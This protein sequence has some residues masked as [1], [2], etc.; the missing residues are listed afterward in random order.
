[1]QLSAVVSTIVSNLSH[2]YKLRVLTNRALLVSAHVSMCEA[3]MNVL[4]KRARATPQLSALGLLTTVLTVLTAVGSSGQ[5]IWLTTQRTTARHCHI[6]HLQTLCAFCAHHTSSTL[7][8]SS[9]T[10]H[11]PRIAIEACDRVDSQSN[12]GPSDFG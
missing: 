12:M 1:M 2:T 5:H 11:R 9:P 8:R 6:T 7:P 3:C 4:R 10:A